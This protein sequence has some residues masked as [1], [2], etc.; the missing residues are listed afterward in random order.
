MDNLK[1]N[2]QNVNLKNQVVDAF[3]EFIREVSGIDQMMYATLTFK[4][5]NT[6][7]GSVHP[8]RAD[9]AFRYFLFNANREIYGYKNWY[10]NKRNGLLVARATEIGKI[11]SH[12]HY[13]CLI[14]RVP[15]NI[16]PEFFKERWEENGFSKIGICKNEKDASEYVAKDVYMAKGGEI[17][18]YGAWK[19]R[20]ELVRS[21]ADPLTSLATQS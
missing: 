14:S 2:F 1:N 8:E 11:G 12:L 9:K 5:A 18:F 3:A 21:Y 6:K 17:D 19:Y 7:T 13:H 16:K 4:P 15:E 20:H 10:K